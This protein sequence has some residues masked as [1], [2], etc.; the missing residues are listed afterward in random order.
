MDFGL[1]SAIRFDG[2]SLAAA[3][4]DHESARL[5]EFHIGHAVAIDID[6]R[7]NSAGGIQPHISITRDAAGDRRNPSAVITKLY[8]QRRRPDRRYLVD[9]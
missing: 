9:I 3:K 2:Y 7:A 5:A 8:V 1:H 6:L 4:L